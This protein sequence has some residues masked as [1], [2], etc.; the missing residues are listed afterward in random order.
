MRQT[1][2]ETEEGAGAGAGSGRHTAGTLSDRKTNNDC[3][4]L[5]FKQNVCR[6]FW[7]PWQKQFNSRGAI[8]NVCQLTL[9]DG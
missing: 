4:W 3:I 9:E 2:A 7:Q 8:S 5:A 6:A 1:E